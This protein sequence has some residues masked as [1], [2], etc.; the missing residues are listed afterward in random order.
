MLITV[1]I[2]PNYFIWKPFCV[3][4]RGYDKENRRTSSA[5]TSAIAGNSS[6]G[7][8]TCRGQC[9]PCVGR[10]ATGERACQTANASSGS[11]AA[12]RRKQRF[13]QHHQ[14][15]G[16]FSKERHGSC[17]RRSFRKRLKCRNQQRRKHGKRAGAKHEQPPKRQHRQLKQRQQGSRSTCLRLS[18]K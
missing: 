7:A 8:A 14:Y 15:S 2:L 10:R 4:G 16:R 13:R 1:T 17:G 11:F 6:N 9:R 3:K 18:P 5:R 12:R